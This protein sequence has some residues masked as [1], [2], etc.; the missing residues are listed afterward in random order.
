[1]NNLTGFDTL[2]A[3]IHHSN[4]V[5]TLESLESILELYTEE[6]GEQYFIDNLML[7]FQDTVSVPQKDD[8]TFA[9]TGIVSDTNR[10]FFSYIGGKPDLINNEIKIIFT[11]EKRNNL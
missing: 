3:I 1:M 5:Y 2:F 6:K 7:D 10:H 9:Y 8:I 4:D 11:G